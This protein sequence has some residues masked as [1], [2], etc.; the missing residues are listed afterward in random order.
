MSVPYLDFLSRLELNTGFF[1]TDTR[2]TT[3][4]EQHMEHQ[5]QKSTGGVEWRCWRGSR[6][7]SV[8]EGRREFGRRKWPT[9]P[10]TQIT[11][12]S[13]RQSVD[14]STHGGERGRAL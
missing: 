6:G 8:A 4:D 9:E 11:S 12:E 7:E 14:Q 3:G 13:N 1:F 5:I 10:Q 2:R